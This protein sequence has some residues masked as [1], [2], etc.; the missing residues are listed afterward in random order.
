MGRTEPGVLLVGA[1]SFHTLLLSAPPPRHHLRQRGDRWAL[2]AGKQRLSACDSARCP[3]QTRV[4]KGLSLSR[5]DLGANHMGMLGGAQESALR[6]IVGDF[7]AACV[8]SDEK[9]IKAEL[10][11]C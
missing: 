4:H 11:F 3:Q 7:Y 10:L 6:Q 5:S 9:K 2:Q 8:Y 1:K